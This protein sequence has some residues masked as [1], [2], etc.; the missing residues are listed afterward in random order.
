MSTQQQIDIIDDQI[1]ELRNKRYKLSKKLMVEQQEKLRVLVGVCFMHAGKFYKIIDVP[2]EELSLSH[3]AFNPYQLPVL[4]IDGDT[5]E[6]DTLFSHAVS[7]NDPLKQLQGEYGIA[8]QVEETAK[9]ELALD[10]L[11]ERLKAIGK[12]DE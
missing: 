4:V 11:V 6:E 5:I 2:Q 3:F 12:S 9:F 7:Y 8:D 10:S 1:L